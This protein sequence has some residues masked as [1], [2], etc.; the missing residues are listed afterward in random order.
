MMKLRNFGE[1]ALSGAAYSICKLEEFLTCLRLQP[2]KE[3]IDFYSNQQ[4]ALISERNALHEFWEWQKELI[5]RLLNFGRHGNELTKNDSEV[6]NFFNSGIYP[7]EK[8]KDQFLEYDLR[9]TNSKISDLK[10]QY[11]KVENEVIPWKIAGDALFWLTIGIGAYQISKYFIWPN[12]KPKLDP[13]IRVQKENKA[14][15]GLRNLF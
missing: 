7:A 14:V 1:T 6:V 3:S 10:L 9:L 2:I 13:Y 4:N 8:F 5:A 11:Q 12:L 15:F